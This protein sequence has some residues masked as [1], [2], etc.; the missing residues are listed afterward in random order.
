VRNLPLLFLSIAFY[1]AFAQPKAVSV[2]HH[3][4]TFSLGNAVA[5]QMFLWEETAPE[6]L[7]QVP[8]KTQIAFKMQN[9]ECVVLF[10][11][12]TG[13][14]DRRQARIIVSL[15]TNDTLWIDTTWLSYRLV[16]LYKENAITIHHTLNPLDS[17]SRK[18]DLN[19]HLDSVRIRIA[20]VKILGDPVSNKG[21]GQR[22]IIAL[23]TL[24]Q[25]PEWIFNMTYDS[26]TYKYPVSPV[27]QFTKP[28]L[29]KSL[30]VPNIDTA[31]VFQHYR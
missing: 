20:L 14:G 18:Y 15:E 5:A 9:R 17:I 26:T 10:D 30:G 23:A 12:V 7:I 8:M 19:F 16:K 11:S 27:V 13:R 2:P 22:A 4:Y 31:K 28:Y 6:T 29:F 24:G 1:H 25:I 3:P 21:A